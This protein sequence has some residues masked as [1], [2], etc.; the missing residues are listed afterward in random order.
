MIEEQSKQQNSKN[1]RL[2]E[3]KCEICRNAYGNYSEK[4]KTC[5]SYE[6][7]KEK[8]AGILSNIQKDRSGTWEM[9]GAV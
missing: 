2:D 9:Q 8:V 6:Q 3:E 5:E 4:D 1:E 7:V